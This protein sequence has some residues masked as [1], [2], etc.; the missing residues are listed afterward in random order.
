MEFQQGHALRAFTPGGGWPDDHRDQEDQRRQLDA[1]PTIIDNNQRELFDRLPGIVL[2]EQQNPTQ[3]NLS[4]RGLGNPQESEYVLLMQDG[5]PLELDWIGYPT[6]YYLPVPQTLSSVQMIRGGSGLLYG[7]EP[8]PVINFISRRPDPDHLAS[9][10]TEQVGGQYG[11]FSSFNRVSGTSGD[12]NYL[13]D[14]SHRQSDGPAGQRRLRPR[15][16]VTCISATASMRTR[17]WRSTCMPIRST[18]ASP[19][20]MSYAQFQADSQQSTTPADHLWT[21]RYTSVLTY[22]NAFSDR[23][24]F[25]QRLWTGYRISSP[26][27]TATPVRIRPPSA[28]PGP[29]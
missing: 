8:Q 29:T 17:A 1:E 4:Y 13:A 15:M 26:A 12:W 19:G 23:S 24:S 7:P 3:L 25:T 22:Q 16:P 2:A 5:I 11:L 10:T 14:F 21:D 20:L 9:G 27:R 6:L 28:R 18:A